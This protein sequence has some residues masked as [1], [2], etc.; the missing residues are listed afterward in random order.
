[1]KVVVAGNKRELAA[2][3]EVAD[4]L[5]S[6]LKGLL[7]RDGLE[8]GSC[9]WIRPCKG[10]HTFFMRFAIDVLV[11]DKERR[12]VAVIHD[13]KPNRMS[14]VYARGATV[15][16]LPAHAAAGVVAGDVI[17]FVPAAKNMEPQ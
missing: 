10:V 6:R 2:V 8:A 15:L 4:S 16:E 7:G 5:F 13:M 14:P 9:L 12:V 3:T 1:M 11:L 17:E